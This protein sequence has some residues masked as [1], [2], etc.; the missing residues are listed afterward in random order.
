VSQDHRNRDGDDQD[1]GLHRMPSAT[2]SSA[3]VAGLPAAQRRRHRAASSHDRPV[4]ST[5]SANVNA[6]GFT[7]AAIR[8]SIV[9]GALP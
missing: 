2:F 6:S 1:G 3:G 7:V 4:A 9:E 8:P 5:T